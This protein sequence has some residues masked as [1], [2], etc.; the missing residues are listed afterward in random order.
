ML[1]QYTG[2][3]L[4]DSAEMKEIKGGFGPIYKGYHCTDSFGISYNECLLP[5]EDPYTCVYPGYTLNC[6]YTGSCSPYTG[7]LCA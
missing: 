4:L 5:S 7:V 3:R 1:Y 6:V 2:L